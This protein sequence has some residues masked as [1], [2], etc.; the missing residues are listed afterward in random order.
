MKNVE[1]INGVEF[2]YEWVYEVTGPNGTSLYR[3]FDP[4]EAHDELDNLQVKARQ[5]DVNAVFTVRRR[6]RVTSMYISEWE[7]VND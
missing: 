3:T 6:K 7:A 2:H 5:I 4:D 1:N